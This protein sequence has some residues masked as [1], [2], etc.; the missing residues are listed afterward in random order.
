MTLIYDFNFT[1][2][3]NSVSHKPLTKCTNDNHVTVVGC[4]GCK[5]KNWS[6]NCFFLHYCNVKWL[7]N[8]AIGKQIWTLALKT[9]S[10]DHLLI[11][12]EHF[13]LLKFQLSFVNLLCFI[14]CTK[15]VHSLRFYSFILFTH[16]LICWLL[17]TAW[18]SPYCFLV[19]VS[20][21]GLSLLSSYG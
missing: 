16:L 3:I 8:E 11:S 7:L 21:S 13:F 6:Q 19:K 12:L 1:F 20:R 17:A 15:W 18:I 10:A 14:Q 5:G 9:I 2:F 4:K